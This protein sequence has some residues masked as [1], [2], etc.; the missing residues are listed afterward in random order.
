MAAVQIAP[1]GT[2]LDNMKKTF[3]QVPVDAANGNAISTEEFLDAAEALTTMFG[4]Y[5]P[6]FYPR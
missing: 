2:F 4:N 6:L 1:G 5:R 3:P